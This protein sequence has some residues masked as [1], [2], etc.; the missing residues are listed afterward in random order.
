MAKYF[1]T[2]SN[3]YD[4][5]IGT[6]IDKFVNKVKSFPPGTCP[7]VVQYTSLRSSVGQT[8][9]KCVPCR[10]GLPQLAILIRKVLDGEADQSV[11]DQIRELALMIRDGSDC[12]IG[13]Q[14][15]FEVLESI[16]EF[17][18]EYDSHIRHK[19]CLD[20]VGQKIPCINMCPAHVDIPGYIAHIGDGNYADAIQLIRKDNP[21][22]TACGLICEH[23]CEERCRRRLID[24]AINIRAL[25]KYA[26]DQVAADTVAVPKPLPD[27]GKKVAVIG[28]GP[29]G[30][31]CAYFLA[32][33]GHRVTLY[34]RQQAL[35]GMLRYGIPNYRFPKVRLDQDLNAILSAGN[36]EVKY[37]VNVGEDISPQEIRAQH[38]AMFVAI[39]AQKGKILR[40]E[41]AD[42]NNVF[43]AVKMLD[44]IGN[45]KIPDYSGKIVVVVGGGN[46][47]MDAARS[48]VR[49]NAKDVR[50][51][52]RRRQDDMT[53][54]HSE[55]EAAIMEGIELITLAAPLAIEK[56][57][58]D[59]C[60]G[61]VVQP[62]MTGPYDHEGRPSPVAAKKPPFSI[63]CDVILIA[64]GQ[65][66]ISL[67]FEQ[68]GMRAKRGIFA[69]DLT[70]AVPD[71]DGVFV[72][73][74]CATGPA[75]AIKAI[76]AG[77]VAAHN[78][79]EYLGYHHEFPCDT[80]APPAKDNLRI[81][82]GRANTT[83]RPAYLRKCDFEHV[84][85]P[86]TYEEAMQEA[87]RCL[88]C[89]HFGC[90]VLQGG[91]NL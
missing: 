7:L 61:L 79:D 14:P 65:D 16:E 47:A 90:G 21:L 89:D 59:D 86:Y 73:G 75:T 12:A 80:K 41:G 57:E 2:P 46:V 72:G 35:G 56:N 37:G 70:T 76:A 67:P 50:I 22:P 1:L 69:S 18:S 8:C 74:D 24:D 9:G 82:V 39:G 13:Y 23:P 31:S 20:N 38:D 44:D 19:S 25:K 66:I 4:T 27:T 5:K 60:V 15:A 26:V 78:I 29:A 77:K 42:A 62:Q 36:I 45:G 40:V 58:L 49:C 87:E 3:N 83:E 28:G 17:K 33:M 34:E 10:D 81:Q 68:F 32:Q 91:R 71:M 88:R 84:E 85:N 53:A 64:V 55:I 51:V 30:L 52:Y 48:A 54:L 43:S 63:A 11:M 6:L